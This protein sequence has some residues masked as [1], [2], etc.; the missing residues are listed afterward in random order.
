VADARVGRRSIR[1]GAGEEFR[2]PRYD[3]HINPRNRSR[4]DLVMLQTFDC[5]TT[6]VAQRYLETLAEFIKQ[7]R[8]VWGDLPPVVALAVFAGRDQ[9]TFGPW[10]PRAVQRQVVFPLARSFEEW[11][12]DRRQERDELKRSG[13]WRS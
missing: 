4:A 5:T 1:L 3:M 11:R 8:D 9:Q 12:E 2:V 10:L 7:G 13:W 6:Y